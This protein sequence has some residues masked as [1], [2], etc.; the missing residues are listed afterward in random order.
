MMGANGSISPT[1]LF[2]RL[3]ANADEAFCWPLLHRSH[4]TPKA[5]RFSADVSKAG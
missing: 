4:A 1:Y 5:L 2:L 3:S